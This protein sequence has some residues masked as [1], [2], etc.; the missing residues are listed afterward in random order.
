MHRVGELVALEYQLLAIRQ[1]RSWFE[2]ELSHRGQSWESSGDAAMTAERPDEQSPTGQ[3]ALKAGPL[4]VIFQR[5]NGIQ[6]SVESHASRSRDSTTRAKFFTNNP[7][8]K[9]FVD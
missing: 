3:M 2:L 7:R 5:L 6:K 9:K 4:I 1:K 8:E